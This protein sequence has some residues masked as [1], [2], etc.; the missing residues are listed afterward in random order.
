MAHNTLQ[1][2]GLI[3]DILWCKKCPYYITEQDKHVIL[4]KGDLTSKTIIILKKYGDKLSRYYYKL[5]EDT[6][7]KNFNR[8]L[9]EDYFITYLPKCYNHSINRFTETEKLVETCIELLVRELD[10]YCKYYNKIIVF[11]SI[12]SCVLQK[13][14]FHGTNLQIVYA[15]TPANTKRFINEFNLIISNDKHMGI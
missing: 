13:M 11:D 7:N 5:L 15:D 14:D 10:Y 3:K 1:S 2:T 12:L 9:K 4:G 8:N 6:Y